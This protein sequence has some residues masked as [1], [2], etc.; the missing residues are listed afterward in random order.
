M[1]IDF[2][3]EANREQI[4]RLS[5]D[6]DRFPTESEVLAHIEVLRLEIAET[7][8]QLSNAGPSLFI[9]IE[10]KDALGHLHLRNL[11]SSLAFAIDVRTLAGA[12]TVLECAG[13]LET[14]L[15]ETYRFVAPNIFG[16]TPKTKSKAVTAI[17]VS[18]KPAKKAKA[19]RKGRGMKGRKHSEETKRKMRLAQRKRHAAAK[20]AK[21]AKAARKSRTRRGS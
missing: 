12:W 13:L 11:E 21:K 16:T 1:A 2:S 15:N 8:A 5:P 19:A 18:K 20:P 9:K 3:I 7:H 10:G 6:G 17:K 14:D 4:R